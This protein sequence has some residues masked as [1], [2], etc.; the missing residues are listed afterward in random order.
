MAP[1]SQTVRERYGVAIYNF[2][3]KRT[4]QLSLC[5][6]DTVQ[7]LEKCEGW[8][9]GCLMKNKLQVGVFPASFVH[10]KEAIIEKRG[11]GLKVNSSCLCDSIK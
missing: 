8:Y 11:Y 1:W 7:I 2:E 9:R 10:V 5:I 3:R 4:P 6:G